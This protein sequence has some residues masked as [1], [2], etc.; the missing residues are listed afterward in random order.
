MAMQ[1]ATARLMAEP[2]EQ[3][4]RDRRS[5]T[6]AA[7]A[8]PTPDTALPKAEDPWPLRAARTPN[9]SGCCRS[10]FNARRSR[11]EIWHG[12]NRASALLI[13]HLPCVPA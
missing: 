7:P 10:S 4:G 1:T 8:G 9:F 5:S 3:N 2:V 12:G 6:P 11:L 13:D